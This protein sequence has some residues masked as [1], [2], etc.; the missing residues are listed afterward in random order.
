MDALDAKAEELEE[1]LME[2]LKPTVGRWLGLLEGHHYHP[3]QAYVDGLD[4]KFQIYK[5]QQQILYQLERIFNQ[6]L[7]LLVIGLQMKRPT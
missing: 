5:D 7:W 6:M 2:L 3:H 1:R 4:T